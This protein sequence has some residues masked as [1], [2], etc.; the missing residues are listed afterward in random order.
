MSHNFLDHASFICYSPLPRFLVGGD[1][2]GLFEV[3]NKT[4]ALVFI[5][6]ENPGSNTLEELTAIF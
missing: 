5:A 3:V 4:E 6:G 1:L 2:C